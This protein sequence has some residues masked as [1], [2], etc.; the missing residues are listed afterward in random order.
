MDIPSILTHNHYAMKKLLASLIFSFSL[1]PLFSFQSAAT[2]AVTTNLI[3]VPP[4]TGIGYQDTD[5]VYYYTFYADLSQASPY[6]LTYIQVQR[7]IGG[8]ILPLINFSGTVVRSVLGRYAI[9]GTATVTFTDDGTT[10][11]KDLTGLIQGGI[12]P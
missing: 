4:G 7:K 5:P 9:N 8:Q 3:T 1:F 6:P 10:V 11:T 12:I 2:G